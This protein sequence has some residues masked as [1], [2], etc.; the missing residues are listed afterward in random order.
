MSSTPTDPPAL[1]RRRFIACAALAAGAGASL[2]AQTPPESTTDPVIEAAVEEAVRKERSRSL[3]N[4]IRGQALHLKP[5]VEKY[6]LD[7]VELITTTT[8]DDA[9]TRYARREIEDRGLEGVKEQLWNNLPPE[10][11][12]FEKVEDTPNRLSF[13]VSACPHAKEWRKLDASDIGFAVAC[14]WDIGFCAGLNPKIRFTRT[15]TLMQG[16]PVCNHTYELEA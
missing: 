15:Q 9:Q 1:P 7:V 4:R 14:C 8:I 11:Y 5:I 16:D 2:R 6:G 3:R 13:R 12:P 10:D